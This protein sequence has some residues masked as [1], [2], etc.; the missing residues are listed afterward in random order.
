MD[1]YMLLP[2]LE[3]WERR[4]SLATRVIT[5]LAGATHVP[6]DVKG[7]GWWLSVG[8]SVTSPNVV[9]TATVDGQVLQKFTPSDL[10]SLGHTKANNASPY[11]DVYDTGNSIYTISWAP[12]IYLPFVDS[13]RLDIFNPTASAVT[14]NEFYG[15]VVL[16]TNREIFESGLRRLLGR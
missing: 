2:L 12:A 14:L 13:A 4:S 3:G 9:V 7:K 8:G 6:L 15:L 1:A 11:L 16:I 10:N 5:I